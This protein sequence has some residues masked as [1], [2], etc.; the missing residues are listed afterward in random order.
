[1]ERLRALHLVHDSP[2]VSSG[3]GGTERYVHALAAFTGD[4][5]MTRDRSHQAPLKKQDSDTYPLWVA[6]APLPQ[7]PRFR[8][9]FCIPEMEAALDEVLLQERPDL[10]HIHHFAHLGFG[11]PEV[12]AAR[13]VPVIFHLHDYQSICTRGQL[14]DRH[15]NRCLGPD[16]AQCASCVLEH[17]RA[18]PSLHVAGKLAEK[19]GIRASARKLAA[20]GTPREPELRPIRARF[21]ATQSAFSHID[22]FLS[23]SANLADRMVNLGWI[24]SNKCFVEDLPLVAPIQPTSRSPEHPFRILFI[25]SL[26]PTKGPQILLEA[27]EDLDAEVHFYGPCPSFDGQPNWGSELIERIE[28]QSNT[29][30]GGTFSDHERSKVYGGGDLLVLPSIWEENSPLVLREGLAAGLPAI[31][32]DVGGMKEIA[33]NATRVK[34]DSVP[35]LRKALEQA[36]AH[37]PNRHPP[38]DWPMPPHEQALQEH[39]RAVCKA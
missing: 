16:E 19:L 15:L 5:V 7:R 20:W 8:D 1:M 37:G 3:C 10:L 38:V 31:V 6:A 18:R 12:A 17:V 23:P 21:K 33:P 24:P 39:Y 28:H 35:E 25:G 32:S 27:A 26:I 30:Y 11:M 2:R 4:P 22:R 13:G 34:P 36:L 9:H 29:Y 14:V